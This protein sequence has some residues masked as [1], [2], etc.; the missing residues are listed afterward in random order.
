MQK[1]NRHEVYMNNYN[2]ILY[3]LR[4]FEYTLLE[5][6]Q[7]VF[8]TFELDLTMLKA[9]AYINGTDL[10]SKEYNRRIEEF[11]K[12]YK[13]SESIK[14]Y[15]EAYEQ[16][17]TYSIKKA[18]LNNRTLKYIQPYSEESC[19]S[20]YN[21]EVFN[22]EEQHRFFTDYPEI[23]YYPSL[24]AD[25]VSLYEN[26]Q[27]KEDFKGITIVSNLTSFYYYFCNDRDFMCNV[28]IAFPTNLAFYITLGNIKTSEVFLD[29]TRLIFD[30]CALCEVLSKLQDY[31]NTQ[32]LNEIF[33]NN[34]PTNLRNNEH[35]TQTEREIYIKISKNPS[36]T[37]KELGNINT[38]NTHIRHITQKLMGEEKGIKALKA[39]I[40]KNQ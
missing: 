4:K 24:R 2:E 5:M 26:F 3:N 33:N 39:Y 20:P 15:Q 21:A 11:Q 16:I 10:I 14:A 40:A 9:K 23:Y 1:A 37:L 22:N 25:N 35:L 30:A 13:K 36:I 19:Y 32:R 6:N 12:E 28:N 18:K 17:K 29:C 31:V 38:A 8:S 27:N 7:K 34:I